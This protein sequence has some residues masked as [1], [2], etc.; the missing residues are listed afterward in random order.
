MERRRG[1]GLDEIPPERKATEDEDRGDDDFDFDEDFDHDG[2][3]DFDDF[4]EDFDE[5]D[6]HIKQLKMIL[7]LIK[8]SS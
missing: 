2:D 4:D 3:H 5:D 7:M 6:E 1:E 8:R